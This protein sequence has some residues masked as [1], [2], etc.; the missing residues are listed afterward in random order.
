VETL[1]N[2]TSAPTAKVIGAAETGELYL[3]DHNH[4]SDLNITLPP[5][6][7]GAYFKFVWKTA[8]TDN[9]ADVVFTSSEGTNG[10]FAGTIIEFT[11]DATDGAVAV[12]TAG[13]TAKT[14]RI[15]SA[16]D[17]SIGSWAECVC[18]GSKWYWTGCQVA[19]A[20]GTV[21]FS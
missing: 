1:G 12:E 10:D 20:V 6:Q 8:A 21:A 5:M 7:D 18:D 19:A 15:G 9:A 4:A 2:G 17:T 16:S 14:L 3:I 11:S 13:G